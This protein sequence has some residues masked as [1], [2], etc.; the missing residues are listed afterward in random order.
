MFEEEFENLYYYLDWNDLL[1]QV[2]WNN[3]NRFQRYLFNTITI[4]DIQQK[5][6]M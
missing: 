5:Y 4:N 6:M 2:D 1:K 3:S